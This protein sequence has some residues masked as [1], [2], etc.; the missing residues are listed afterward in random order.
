MFVTDNKVKVLMEGPT[1]ICAVGKDEESVSLG[2][3]EII[4]EENFGERE[5]TCLEGGKG[6]PM[7]GLTFQ[8]AESIQVIAAVWRIC[9]KGTWC[10][11]EMVVKIVG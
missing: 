10:N 3:G 11:S 1:D 5:V 6:D 7:A 8:V 9:E 4:I 2:R